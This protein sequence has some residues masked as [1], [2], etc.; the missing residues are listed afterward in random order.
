MIK[1]ASKWRRHAAFGGAVMALAMVQAGPALASAPIVG[2]TPTGLSA[3]GLALAGANCSAPS[4][5]QPFAAWGDQNQYMLA[6]GQG[7]AGFSGSGW[8]LY[9]TAR[10]APA[11]AIDGQSTT[12]LDLPPVSVAVSAPVCVASDYPIARTLVRTSGGA[13]V[14][15]A[16]VYA[17]TLG[18]GVT[19]SVLQTGLSGAIDG[20]AS[21]GP[22]APVQVHPGDLPG[23]QVV[24]F[25]F[26]NLTGGTAQLD[27]FY[28][29]PRMKS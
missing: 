17:D 7:A 4:L 5:S 20:V 22:S 19:E 13:R 1:R 8:A 16:A 18:P 29:D 23:W 15:V 3:A 11:T 21:W 25:V 9:G 14:A 27:H 28:V 26:A 24:Q 2:V 6:P 12:V 10:F